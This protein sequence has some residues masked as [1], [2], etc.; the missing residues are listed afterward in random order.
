MTVHHV[1]L[2]DA[3]TMIESGDL[4]NSLAVIGIL[5]VARLLGI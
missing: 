4:D 5:R 1:P 2:R 3:L